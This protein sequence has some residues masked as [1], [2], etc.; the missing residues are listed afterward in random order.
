MGTLGHNR[1]RKGT[2]GHVGQSVESL[3]VL[4]WKRVESML[5]RSKALLKAQ[6]LPIGFEKRTSYAILTGLFNIIKD[7]ASYGL[8][9]T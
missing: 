6:N 4:C 8:V 1:E 9:R 2:L 5:S 3:L 7:R